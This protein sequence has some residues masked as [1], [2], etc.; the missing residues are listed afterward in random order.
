MILFW[1]VAGLL[2]A[3]ALLVLLRPLVRPPAGAD[4]EPAAAMFRRQLAAIDGEAAQG[5]LD[6]EAAAAAR[7]EVTRRMLGAAERDTAAQAPSGTG[8][9]A[10]RLSTAVGI[11]GVL[12]AA[13]LAIYALVGT[14]AAIGG[15][16]A[17]ATSPQ[18]GPHSEA[19]LA[20]AVQRLRAK[21]KASPK[22]VEAWVLLGRTLVA[23]DRYPDSRDAFSHAVQLAPNQP[24][25][26]AELGEAM[27][28]EAGGRVT[29]A[30]EAEFAK[31]GNDP[32]ARFYGAEAKA[33]RGD[34]AGAKAEL[35]ALLKDAP[36]DAPW[37]KVVARQLAQ[38]APGTATPAA[39]DTAPGPSAAEVAAAAKMSPT[40]RQ[41]MIRGMVGRL[42][43][44]M[45]KNPGDK[46]GWLRLARAYD[47]LGEKDK[48]AAARS[49]ADALTDAAPAQPQS[50]ATTTPASGPTAADVAAARKL[51]PEQQ[52]A[53]IA[54][55]VGRLAA[56]MQQHPEDAQG[57]MRLARSYQVLGRGA[58]ALAALKSGSEHVPGNVALLTAYMDALAGGMSDEHPPADLVAV[59]TRVNALDAKQPDAL[60]YL[61]LAAA[62]RGDKFRAAGYWGKL[63]A[64]LP[65]G[66]SQQKL[67]QQRLD[68]LR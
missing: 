21:V 28:L 6:P 37:R 61:G 4:G 2:V 23:L 36:A 60:W 29:P 54:G 33:Q 57:W 55:M 15:N 39:D 3:A 10:W 49:R 62:T 16:P 9:T 47:V 67:V 48:A 51:S 7:T 42:A 5:R 35:V 24:E 19:E 1:T 59:A 52:Q 14:P 32:R 26:H 30:A 43:A 25:L 65:P 13:A 40:D 38:I 44:K 20:T 41:A 63:A 56:R 53:M 46:Q 64:E 8:D 50:A 66:S 27:V 31:S 58:D 12:P 34:I 11:A 22:D 68:S 45:A 18:A 17:V